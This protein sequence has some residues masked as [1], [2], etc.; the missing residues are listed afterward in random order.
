MNAMARLARCATF[1]LAVAAV[2]APAGEAR[3]VDADTAVKA[4]KLVCGNVPD[5]CGP[6]DDVILVA[7]ACL[8]KDSD[9]VNC[10]AKVAS[11]SGNSG[12]QQ[13]YD[14]YLLVMECTRNATVKEPVTA[15][16]DK[17]L[18]EA[19][20]PEADRIE[21]RALVTLC[22][23]SQNVDD[24]VVC[25]DALL[26]SSFAAD[27]GINPPSWVDTMFDIYIDI[28]TPDYLSLIQHVGASA[29]CLAAQILGG[30]D[31]CGVLETLAAIGGAI[32]DGFGAVGEFLSDLFGGGGCNYEWNGECVH[33]HQLL[34][35]LLEAGL[36]VSVEARKA[37][38]AQ[39]AARRGQAFTDIKKHQVFVLGG[40][41]GTP[42]DEEA[43]WTIHTAQVY[44]QWDAAMKGVVDA[45]KSRIEA[46]LQAVKPLELVKVL[47]DATDSVAIGAVT[48]T[49]A[50]CMAA[51]KDE[52]DK[53][54]AWT[55]AGRAPKGMGVL[56]PDATCG[57]RVAQAL[58]GGLNACALQPNDTSESLR[59][60]CDTAV[61]MDACKV[62]Q[63][64]YGNER[65]EACAFGKGGEKGI[66]HAA[67]KAWTPMPLVA[68]CTY[69]EG[70][71][72]N[73]FRCNDPAAAKE[74]SARI[75]LRYSSLD[76]PK[77]G[78]A[79]CKVLETPKRLKA[80]AD[81]AKALQA[82]PGVVVPGAKMNSLGCKP[83]GYDAAIVSCVQVVLDANQ[84]AKVKTAAGV[85]VRQC[86]PAES[87]TK[88]T[89]AWLEEACIAQEPW[90][91]VQVTK[92]LAKPASTGPA[93]TGKPGPGGAPGA[94]LKAGTGTPGGPAGGLV[95]GRTGPGIVSPAQPGAKTGPGVVNPATPRVQP[96]AI[97]K[98]LT[99]PSSL[100]QPG[101]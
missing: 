24:V 96:G 26:G 89:N 58:L 38:D 63:A 88:P 92:D 64:A 39:W 35:K 44:P 66:A 50:K 93:I 30:I 55:Q 20:M 31:V 75:G 12:P 59:A 86:T 65:V 17:K 15:D 90:K 14:R 70:T 48:G 74:C 33:R 71:F 84:V 9:E 22:V 54:V 57:Y 78:I 28:R 37:G 7:D 4:V 100:K 47:Q 72:T 11:V 43:A 34:A 53:I 80:V 61:A 16:C 87:T 36:A 97:D 21:A 51:S 82:I 49:R 52:T 1:L 27:A 101:P 99:A 77:A 23:Q 83:D 56:K 3:A 5:V 67:L 19:G 73:A 42:Q 8:K 60:T 68:R 25:A 18:A 95:G 62:A 10:A 85:P 46:A 98:K 2:L 69:E 45:R 6:Y 94:G 29:A 76:W 91:N 41:P 79:E 13:A 40:Y 81:A 32:A